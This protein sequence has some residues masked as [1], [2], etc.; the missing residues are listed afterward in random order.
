MIFHASDYIKEN[1]CNSS[2]ICLIYWDF[3]TQEKVEYRY[4]RKAT[5]LSKAEAKIP[6][7][8]SD[9]AGFDNGA[10]LIS[11]GLR[12][13]IAWKM[14]EVKAYV[15]GAILPKGGVPVAASG[16]I[17]KETG[18]VFLPGGIK[19]AVDLPSVT[20]TPRESQV[21][22]AQQVTSAATGI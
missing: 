20:A 3:F 22:V 12:T 18:G 2:K 6:G 1:G 11:P 7:A 17:V 4:E 9:I 15:R 8:Q 13:T 14:D 21:V 5:K 16:S 19:E 10:D